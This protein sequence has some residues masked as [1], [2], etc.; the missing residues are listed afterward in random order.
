MFSSFFYSPYGYN[1]FQPYRGTSNAYAFPINAA[2]SSGTRRSL[3]CFNPSVPGGGY[4][5]PMVCPTNEE[6][7]NYITNLEVTRKLGD[8]SNVDLGR[9][10]EP[11]DVLVY[12]YVHGVWTLE[13]FISG[14]EF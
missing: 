3:N 2:Q 12:D 10:P 6:I 4:N 11:N 14:G 13:N 7:L 5:G 9:A 8:L 1:P